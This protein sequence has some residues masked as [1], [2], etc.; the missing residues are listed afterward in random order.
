V[1]DRLTISNI[2]GGSLAEGQ[3]ASARRAPHPPAQVHAVVRSLVL[4]TQQKSGDWTL[5]VKGGLSRA[6]EDTPESLNDGRF[7]GS[8]DFAGI[9]FSN[10]E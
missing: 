9:G 7:R 2:A 3:T 4:G 8:K 1:R 6:T 5:D 10:T